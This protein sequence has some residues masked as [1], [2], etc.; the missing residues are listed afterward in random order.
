MGHLELEAVT[1]DTKRYRV[2]IQVQVKGKRPGRKERPFWDYDLPFVGF[3][4]A[5]HSILG[6]STV[7]IHLH[8]GLKTTAY[9]LCPFNVHYFV[10]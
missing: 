3:V 5:H 1:R 10:H 4:F 9:I 2:L 8:T 6:L 7:Y